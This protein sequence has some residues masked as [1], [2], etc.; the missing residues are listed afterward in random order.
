MIREKHLDINL[1]GIIFSCMRGNNVVDPNDR[2]VITPTGEVEEE[3]NDLEDADDMKDASNAY[4]VLVDPA[5]DPPST[6]VNAPP[7]LI[8]MMY[9][10][11]K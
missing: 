7:P 3:K 5:N 1:S 2:S 6:E 4:L 11:Y 8:Q 10:L 9:R